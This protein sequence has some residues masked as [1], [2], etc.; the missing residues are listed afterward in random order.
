MTALSYVPGSEAVP[1]A[2][3]PTVLLQRP[4][5]VW[6]LCVY[7]KKNPTRREPYESRKSSPE[8]TEVVFNAFG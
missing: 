2:T 8:V 4:S 5:L 3:Q 6:Q 1:N 7:Y